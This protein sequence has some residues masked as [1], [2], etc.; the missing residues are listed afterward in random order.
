MKKLSAQ[1]M[2]HSPERME[3]KYC[4]AGDVWAA[5]NIINIKL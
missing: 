2:F 5:G 3:E 4:Q 1:P